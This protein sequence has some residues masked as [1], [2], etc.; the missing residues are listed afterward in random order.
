M[1]IVS[2]AALFIFVTVV[3]AV[4]ITRKRDRESAEAKRAWWDSF[5]SV[6]L[7]SSLAFSIG[8]FLFVMQRKFE[9]D[10]HRE[11]YRQM[12]SNEIGYIMLSIDERANLELI[13][14][15]DTL[16]VKLIYLPHAVLEEAGMSGLFPRQRSWNMLAVA[17][18]VQEHN[19]L[20]EY[21]ISSLASDR[22]PTRR[23]H[24]K[25]AV[26]RLNQA[27]AMVHQGSGSILTQ[28]NLGVSSAAFETF[29]KNMGSTEGS[30]SST[31]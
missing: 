11:A 3:I 25:Y 1:W 18:M 4:V 13:I 6:L 9:D 30:A 2:I 27:S 15:T 21:L 31:F 22:D 26:E 19:F 10:G 5:L 7:S 12:L 28:L 29:G 17:A 23:Q 8:L 20:A 16:E 24:V 14:E